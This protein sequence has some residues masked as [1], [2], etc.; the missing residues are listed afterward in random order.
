[1]S[2][3]SA[4]DQPQAPVIPKLVIPTE[5]N[6]EAARKVQLRAHSRWH[7]GLQIFFYDFIC[8]C[9]AVLGVPCCEGFSLI[10]VTLGHSL[11]AE[12]WLLIMVAS[13]VEHRL[14]STLASVVAAHLHVSRSFHPHSQSFISFIQI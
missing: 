12:I 1:M 10:T 2:L 5:E 4:T 11:V 6:T 13:P 8:L 3:L 7:W 14:W 9:L